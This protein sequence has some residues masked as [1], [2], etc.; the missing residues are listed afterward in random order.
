M[1]VHAS[2]W[3]FIMLA[4]NES[5]EEW[6]SLI[7]TG[8]MQSLT[9]CHEMLSFVLGLDSMWRHLEYEHLS[10]DFIETLLLDQMMHEVKL[11]LFTPK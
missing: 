6:D 9:R 4:S 8:K 7:D 11:K 10:G 1:D 5:L 3:Y 2:K